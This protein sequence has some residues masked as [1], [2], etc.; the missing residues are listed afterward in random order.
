MDAALSLTRLHAEPTRSKGSSTPTTAVD[1]SARGHHRILRVA[2][3][4]AD[5]EQSA[6]VT[7]THVL[8]AL[9]DA[10]PR[11]RRAARGLRSAGGWRATIDA[12][13]D[14]LRRTWLLGALS[15]FLE[16]MRERY[17]RPDE[18]MALGDRELIDGLAGRRGTWCAPRT[19]ASTP[20][21]R[22]R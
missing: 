2:R 12:C 5:L 4:I 18:L 10:R 21:A 13:D 9:G 14:C 8:L 6:T 19:R 3:T 22:A 20:P 11:P 16:A 15:P 17:G 7:R 1:L